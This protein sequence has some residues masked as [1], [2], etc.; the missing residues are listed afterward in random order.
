MYRPKGR[1]YGLPILMYRPKGRR[2]G[3]PIWDDEFKSK[4]LEFSDVPP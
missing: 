3:L 2:Y 4:D 1:R